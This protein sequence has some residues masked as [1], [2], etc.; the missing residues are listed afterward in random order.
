MTRRLLPISARAL[1]RAKQVWEEQ[2]AANGRVVEIF[3]AFDNAITS[4]SGNPIKAFCKRPK[5][6]GLFDRTEQSFDQEKF[7]VLLSASDLPTDLEP[8]KF[9]RIKWDSIEHVVINATA[10]S[11]VRESCSSEVELRPSSSIIHCVS[12]RFGL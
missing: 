11:A 8:E 5:I 9:H 2:I 6:M 4:P 1:T 7:T 10:S 12:R 3:D